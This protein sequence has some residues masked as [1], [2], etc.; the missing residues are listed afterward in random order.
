MD[1]EQI[2]QARERLLI[3][4]EDLLDDAARAYAESQTLGK[5]GVPD[6]GDMSSNSYTQE[7]LMSLSNAQ[8]R[9]A[10]DIDAALERLDSGVYGLCARCEEEIPARRMEVRPFSRYCVEC[11]SEVEKYGE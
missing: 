8:R 11:K 4:R 2:E 6:I 7:V 9:S 1:P 5:D 3:M 10:A